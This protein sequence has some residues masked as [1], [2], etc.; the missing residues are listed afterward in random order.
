MKN[1]G[2]ISKKDILGIRPGESE[3]FLFDSAKATRSAITYVYQLAQ[4]EDD[5]PEGV[6]KYRT[7]ADYKNH[8]ATITA[9]SIE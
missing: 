4:Y 7:S 9:I 5:L 1:V 6:L 3:E 2:R 8:K